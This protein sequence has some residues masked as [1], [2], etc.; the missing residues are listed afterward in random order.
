M[1]KL[2]LNSSTRRKRNGDGPNA[3]VVWVSHRSTIA[4]P[5][6]KGAIEFRGGEGA[7]VGVHVDLES[8]V[9][10]LSLRN[11]A[12]RHEHQKK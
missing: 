5:V 11:V 3:V 2:V 9:G 6:V 4:T 12:H 10:G 8:Y 1:R 7:G